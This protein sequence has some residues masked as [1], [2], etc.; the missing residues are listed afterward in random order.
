MI[1]DCR[2]YIP[3]PSTESRISNH[4]FANVKNIC[5]LKADH[6]DYNGVEAFATQMFWYLL[7]YTSLQL[8]IFCLQSTITSMH[9]WSETSNWSDSRAN[10]RFLSKSVLLQPSWDKSLH[11]TFLFRRK[12]GSYSIPTAL[13]VGTC[14]RH[15]H[16]LLLFSIWNI[17][18]NRQIWIMRWR[19]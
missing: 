7:G 1:Q 3:F 13:N 6:I 9:S 16:N 2:N 5:L 10:L 15:D 19:E 11:K 14:A 12:L 18:T 4:L 8:C 17:K